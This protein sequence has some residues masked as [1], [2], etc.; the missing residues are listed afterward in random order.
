MGS[1]RRYD[2][3]RMARKGRGRLKLQFKNIKLSPQL[4]TLNIGLRDNRGEVIAS[5]VNNVAGFTIIKE[6]NEI[7]ENLNIGDS[8]IKGAPVLFSYEWEYK[9]NVLKNE[10]QEVN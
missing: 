1:W 9:G 7:N 8:F 3:R 2:C 5:T 4:F 6:N 10:L